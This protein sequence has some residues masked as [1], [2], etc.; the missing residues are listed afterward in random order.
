MA[1]RVL[2]LANWRIAAKSI[3]FSGAA[4]RGGSNLVSAA[5]VATAGF[6]GV[7]ITSALYCELADLDPA[8]ARSIAKQGR[9]QV[10]RRILPA[11]AT[12]NR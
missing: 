6:C 8:A 3:G 11:I 7:V 2:K 4:D 12:C 9:R 10:Y 5:G 1:L